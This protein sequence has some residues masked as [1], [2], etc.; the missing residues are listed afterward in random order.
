MSVFRPV[1]RTQTV[2]TGGPVATRLSI[3]PIQQATIHHY[4]ILHG[5]YGEYHRIEYSL[6]SR[7]S[8]SVFRKRGFKPSRDRKRAVFACEGGPL[9]HGRG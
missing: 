6:A 8:K 3:S 1:T 2:I 4:D 9:P 5:Y 7:R